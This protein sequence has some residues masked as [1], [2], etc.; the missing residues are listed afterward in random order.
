[1]APWQHILLNF[2]RATITGDCWVG[3]SE[4]GRQR[5]K[6]M[7]F[8][9]KY[10]FLKSAN[11]SA[12]FGP[13]ACQTIFGQSLNQNVMSCLSQW[14]LS[15]DVVEGRFNIN[16]HKLPVESFSIF[17]LN[18]IIAIELITVTGLKCCKRK[19]LS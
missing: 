7:C 2:R 17:N 18:A 8:K 13:E 1:M 6:Y 5:P 9:I 12:I 19:L 3:Q 14:F 11:C 4:F 10:V 16:K 15:C